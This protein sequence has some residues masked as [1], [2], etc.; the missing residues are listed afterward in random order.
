LFY[1]FTEEESI[2]AVRKL[3]EFRGKEHATPRMARNIW[4][5]S[6]M[7]E[8]MA[9]IVGYKVLVLKGKNH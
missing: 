2:E 1:S 3:L 8:R 4:K 9:Y 5:M 7:Q 6:S